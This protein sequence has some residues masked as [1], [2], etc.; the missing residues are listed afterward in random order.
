MQD[1]SQVQV[2]MQLH[3]KDSLLS[4][5]GTMQSSSREPTQKSNGSWDN[6]TKNKMH[7]GGGVHVPILRLS[8]MK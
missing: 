1:T 2:C 8:G 5:R 4:T 3:A 6:P 7:R